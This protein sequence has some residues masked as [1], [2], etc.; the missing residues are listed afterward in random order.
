[1]NP[2]ETLVKESRINYA[3]LITIEQNVEVKFIGTLTEGDFATVKNAV[4]DCWRKK[5]KNWHSTR[6]SKAKSKS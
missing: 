6:D 5:K 1:M 3:K 2:H 4:D